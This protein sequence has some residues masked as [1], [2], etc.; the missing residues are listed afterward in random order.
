MSLFCVRLEKCSHCMFPLFFLLR[1]FFFFLFPKKAVRSRN[2]KRW[3]SCR[4][5]YFFLPPLIS[6][7]LLLDI[8][9]FLSE[10]LFLFKR[11]ISLISVWTSPALPLFLEVVGASC[12]CRVLF[13]YPELRW[14][15]RMCSFCSRIPN[16]WWGFISGK[17]WRAECSPVCFVVTFASGRHRH[18]AKSPGN[19]HSHHLSKCFHEFSSPNQSLHHSQVF[20][21][22]LWEVNQAQHINFW[23]RLIC[24]WRF[25][26]MISGLK[27]NCACYRIPTEM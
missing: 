24:S 11:G 27:I 23:V 25:H 19:K 22:C 6:L 2:K 17:T 4:T 16:R 1:L 14:G 9:I 3:G 7:V 21:L 20:Q 12:N 26:N 18:M 15:V 13:G 8:Q 5:T 10:D